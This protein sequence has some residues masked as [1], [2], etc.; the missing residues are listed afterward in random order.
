MSCLH[1]VHVQTHT[2]QKQFSVIDRGLYVCA[3][4]ECKKS[5]D[6]DALQSGH[7]E[8]HFM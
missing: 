2:N 1:H 5:Q 8:L 7:V 4:K 3:E 6:R